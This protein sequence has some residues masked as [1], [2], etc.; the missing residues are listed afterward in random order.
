VA[1]SQASAL[2]SLHLPGRPA[3]NRVVVAMSGG[4]DSSVVA[5]LLKAEGYDV[6]GITLQLY[7]HGEAVGRKGA[8]C[9]G[10]DIQD[11][12]RVA[13]V[14]QIPHYV[15]DYEAR[16]AEAVMGEFADSYLHGET[17]VPCVACNQKIKFHDL[18]QMAE[19]L[20]AAALATGHYVMS[21][22]GPAGWELYRAADKERDQSYFLF[23]TTPEQLA[24]LRFPLGHR[25]KDET[26]KLARDFGLAVAKKSDSQDICF[27]PTGRY[28]QVI[29]RL[30]P[31]AVEAGNIVHVDGRVLGRHGGIINYT[32]GQRKG[33]G[34]PAKEPLYVLK[35]DASCREVVVGP[36]EALRTRTL[37][38][39]DVNW[40]GDESFEN[41][42]QSGEEILARI[43]S[44]G[45]L[46]PA[47]L[48][49]E[50]DGVTVELARGEDGVS[51]GQACV[52]YAAK[53]GGERL[54]GG[55]WIKSATASQWLARDRLQASASSGSEQA[56][57]AVSR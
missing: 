44:S 45:P 48:G 18:L 42:A 21:K 2:N 53:G 9:A 19:G 10:Q 4:V 33:I 12:R 39:R 15:L 56:F 8:C 40:L 13:D 51:P 49:I 25:H 16:F 6:I 22:P 30:R 14:L 35:L 50:E 28:T 46:Q 23:A 5:A 43:R 29:E 20:G 38:L 7:D 26:R 3:D 11:A 54:L 37:K 47:H 1:S 55:G 34:V 41:F 32:I 27:V 36:R 24:F 57:A 17:P 31:G 52:F